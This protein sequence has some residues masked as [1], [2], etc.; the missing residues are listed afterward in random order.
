MRRAFFF[1]FFL[2][3]AGCL[4]GCSTPSRTGM[5][6]PT[7]YTIIEFAPGSYCW[8]KAQQANAMCQHRCCVA[9]R[10]QNMYCA[11]CVPEGSASL[12]RHSEEGTTTAVAKPYGNI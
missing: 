4:C 5:K 9:A 12:K 11:A 3:A 10:S 6:T 7:E 2:I 8:F 1:T